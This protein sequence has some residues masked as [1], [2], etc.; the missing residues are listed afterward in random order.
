MVF[1]MTTS[2]SNSGCLGC[3]YLKQSCHGKG[4]RDFS[5]AQNPKR[6]AQIV[7]EVPL[8]FSK[9]KKFTRE[10]KKRDVFREDSRGKMKSL[11]IAQDTTGEKS[12]DKVSLYTIGELIK[13]LYK[14]N[15]LGTPLI[16]G[17]LKQIQTALMEMASIVRERL[18]DED[19][20]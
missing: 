7:S 6:F 5:C 12:G 3:Q 20:E 19:E 2:L 9:P 4:L 1:I 10:I 11:D 16:I 17:D 8:C 15:L 18:E 14:R 13:S